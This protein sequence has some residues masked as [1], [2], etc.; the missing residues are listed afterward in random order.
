MGVSMG[1]A[2]EPI[3]RFDGGSGP[4]A[5]PTH[6]GNLSSSCQQSEKNC[7][8]LSLGVAHDNFYWIESASP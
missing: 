7:L 6:M 5:R 3:D 4:T 8:V 1:A 2:L